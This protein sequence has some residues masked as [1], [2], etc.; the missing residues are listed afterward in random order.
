MKV[1]SFTERRVRETKN[2]RDHNAYLVDKI[3]KGEEIPVRLSMTDVWFPPRPTIKKD[4]KA[5]NRLYSKGK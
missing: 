4:I 3:Q 2:R 1:L 5:M